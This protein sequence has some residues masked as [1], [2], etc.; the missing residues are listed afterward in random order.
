MAQIAYGIAGVEAFLLVLMWLSFRGAR[1]WRRTPESEDVS[2]EGP[3]GNSAASSGQE[4]WDNPTTSGDFDNPLAD[5]N[6]EMYVEE[7]S[8]EEASAKGKKSKKGGKK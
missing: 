3:S 7:A 8:E 4:E 6:E 5:E 1:F 2:M